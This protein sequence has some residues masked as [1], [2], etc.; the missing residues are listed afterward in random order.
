[1]PIAVASHPAELPRDAHRKLTRADCEALAEAGLLDWERFELIDGELIPKMPK[2]PLHTLTLLLLVEWLREVFGA[3]YVRQEAPIDLPVSLHPINEPEPNAAVLWGPAESFRTRNPAP[4]DIRLVAEVTV[5]TQDYD[6]GAKAALY[7]SAGIVEYWVLD[8]ADQ[9]I[10]VHRD[11]RAGEYGSIVAYSA[12]EDVS[13][14]AS[15]A[16]F[17]RLATLLG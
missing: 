8:L 9:R 12:D 2:S 15:P 3:R 17:V 14:L 1:M 10:V 11:P 5:T 6:L 13:P 16:T 7:A 4:T